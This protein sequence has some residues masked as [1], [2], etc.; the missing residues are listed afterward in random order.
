MLT[1]EQTLSSFDFETGRLLPDRLTRVAHAQ[2]LGYAERMLA[3]YR[4][5][6][7]RPRQELH[8]GVAD[9]LAFEEDCPVRRV[10]AFAKLLDDASAYQ[11]DRTGKAA[12]LRRDVFRRAARSHPLVHH[13]DQLFE[14]GETEVKEAIA[15]ELGRTW[16]EIDADLFADIPEFHRLERFDGYEDAAALLARYNVAQVQA[17]LYGAVSLSIW[18]TADFKTILRYAKLARL[19]HTIS[20]C[21]DDRW[22][23]RLDGPASVI[24]ETQRYGVQL[25][26]FLPALIACRGWKMTAVIPVGRSGWRLR[27]T[28]TAEDGLRSHLPPPEEFDSEVEETFASGWGPE[29]REG[30]RL[31]R[32][33]EI[34]VDDQRV[35]FPDF[36]FQH[37]D[38]RRTHLE[39]IGFWTPEYLQAKAE[40]LR[41]F[42]KHRVVV[43][44]ARSKLASIPELAEDPIVYKTRLKVADV[45]D[46]LQR[47]PPAAIMPPP[48]ANGETSHD[49]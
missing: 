19:L 46:R 30:W 43:A 21:G 8:R 20:R 27:L 3:L 18:A 31:L 42:A 12:A 48:S 40:T 44:I 4:N 32:E 10:A 16:G 41:R 11:Q 29:P 17:A 35:F 24:R 49:G 26:K 1:K 38:G 22:L 39:I 37:E 6:V 13:P 23:I 5:G 2:Y 7:G 9:I 28:L 47:A 45:L 36:T 33:S 15:A 14:R 25:A 34:L